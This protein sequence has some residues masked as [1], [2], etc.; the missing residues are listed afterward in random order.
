MVLHVP[1]G[2]LFVIHLEYGVVGTGMANVV[3]AALQLTL[4]L[5]STRY[6]CEDIRDAVFMPDSRI[7]DFKK[8]R[9]CGQGCAGAPVSNPKVS[10]S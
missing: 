4:L 10:S 5:L 9:V 6:L 8:L 1:L 3:T 7:F 2:Y